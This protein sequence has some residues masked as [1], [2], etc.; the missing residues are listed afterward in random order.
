M[1]DDAIHKP[2]A[3]TNEQTETTIEKVVEQPNMPGNPAE[4][5]S[6][7]LLIENAGQPAEDTVREPAQDAASE[8][9]QSTAS[10]SVR[11]TAIHQS[12]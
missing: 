9:A 7:T 6:N 1:S 4:S 8:G 2:S 11:D 12:S 5:T 3:A 10:E